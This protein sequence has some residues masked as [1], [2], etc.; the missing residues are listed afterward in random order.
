M[1]RNKYRQA[2][3]ILRRD[4][5]AAAK[6][7][8]EADPYR[9]VG[10]AS[11]QVRDESEAEYAAAQSAQMEHVKTFA[12]R[13]REVRDDDLILWRGD[14]YRVR[15]VDRY[16]HG[17]REIRVRA[18]VSKSRYTILSQTETNDGHANI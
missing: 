9:E 16:D 7:G 13:T 15:R 3:T 4:A 2:I 11:A 5:E 14:A 12:M 8:Y 10:K 6:G 17:G 1:S 18:S